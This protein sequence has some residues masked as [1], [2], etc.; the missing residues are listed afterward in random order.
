MSLVAVLFV[1]ALVGF[2]AESLRD[3]WFRDLAAW[4]GERANTQLDFVRAIDRADD[5]LVANGFSIIAVPRH[6]R[7]SKHQFVFAI[8]QLSPGGIV[9]K[10]AWIRLRLSFNAKGRVQGV[11]TSLLTEPEHSLRS[12]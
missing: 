7:Q 10:P 11:H 6:A 5:W 1:A 8:K 2:A 9:F 12:S 3:C 4:E